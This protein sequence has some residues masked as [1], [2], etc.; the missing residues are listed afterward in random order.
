M[1]AGP[2]RSAFFA[3]VRFADCWALFGPT[4]TYQTTEAVVRLWRRLVGRRPD[5]AVYDLAGSE[6]ELAGMPIT[7]VEAAVTRL[8]QIGA[9]QAPLARPDG[10]WGRS[11][12][13]SALS[14][15]PG[16]RFR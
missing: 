13:P 8:H 16:A 2:R 9:V 12:S 3:P 4:Q 10:W 1:F 7:D 14:I 5:D 6:P 15:V 11:V